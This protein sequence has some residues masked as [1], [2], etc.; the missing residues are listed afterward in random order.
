MSVDWHFHVETRLDDGWVPPEPFAGGGGRFSWMR[1]NAVADLLFFGSDALF[2][3][4]HGRPPGRS[5]ICRGIDRWWRRADPWEQEMQPRWIAFGGLMVELWSDRSLSVTAPVP[6]GLAPLFGDGD[7]PLPMMAPGAGMAPDLT[8]AIRLGV[9]L[10]AAPIDRTGG[11]GRSELDRRPP[12]A[13]VAVTW[14]TSVDE[15]LGETAE[16]FR[17]LGDLAP[18]EALRVIALLG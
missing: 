15:L 12:H 3:F 7:A 5:E 18:P 1:R 2:A 9:R 6:V 4:E 8:H 14:R 17:R 11:P 10:A 16:D 13:T